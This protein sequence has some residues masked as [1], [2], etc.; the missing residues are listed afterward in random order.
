MLCRN[1]DERT[2]EFQGQG[3]ALE[4]AHAG[5]EGVQPSRETPGLEV[6][7]LKG[8]K[9]KIFVECNRLDLWSHLPILGH[10]GDSQA[11]ARGRQVSQPKKKK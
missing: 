1:Q 11:D 3:A 7:G 9:K 10:R 8:R 6:E 4:A 2:R 5:S